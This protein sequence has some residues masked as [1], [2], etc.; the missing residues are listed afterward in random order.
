MRIV[1][2]M[3]GMQ[4]PFSSH[5]GVGR[6]TKGMVS[7]LIKKAGELHEILLALNGCFP[8]SVKHVRAAFGD[9]LPR[10]NIKIWQQYV[11]PLSGISQS[12]WT[13]RIAEYVREWFLSQFDPDVIWSTNLQ[14]GWL[15]DAV[16]SVGHLKTRALVVSTL[17]DVTPLMFEEKYL[18]GNSVRQWYLEK[19]DFA[20]QSDVI[21]T[22]SC[23][24][25]E[26]IIEFLG[27]DREK[28][29][30]CLLSCNHDI[31]NTA[32]NIGA[33]FPLSD[34]LMRG[35]YVFYVGGADEHKNL[36]RLVK[37]YSRLG[38][39]LIRQYP[40]VLAGRDVR[41]E[42]HKIMAVAKKCGLSKKNI[43]FPGFVDDA[44][45]ASL[46]R[47]CAVFVFPSYS[48]GFG[49]PCLEAMACG[50]PVVAANAT[51]LPEIMD[52]SDA[53][54]DPYDVRDMA[55][56]IHRCLAD[57]A[58]REF[59]AEYGVKR[60]QQFSWES[61]AAEILK[62]FEW[63][64]DRR[65][66]PTINDKG[67]RGTQGIDMLIAKI[68]E[69]VPG[70]EEP[71]LLQ[72]SQ[73][74][75]D[76]MT[77]EK[78]NRKIF[79]DISSLVHVD[80][81]TGIQRVTRA[82]AKILPDV[83]PEGFSV[84]TV[85]SY[86]GHRWFYFAI[87]SESGFSVPDV[88][89]LYGH[90]VDFSDGD[91]LLFLDLHPGNAI[92]KSKEI[93]RLKDRGVAVYFFVYDILPVQYPAYFTPEICQ[94][95]EQW[96]ETVF[97]ADGAICISRTVAVEL[98]SWARDKKMNFTTGFC[99]GWSH[100][101]GDI[102]DS[103][104]SVGMPQDAQACL[105]RFASAHTF[106]MV[107]TIEPRKGH[108]LVLDV[109][110]RLWQDGSENVSFVIVG[111]PAWWRSDGLEARL[112]SHPELDRRLFWLSGITD[113]YLE[114]IYAAAT[115]LI[116]ASEAEGFGLP[117]IEAARHKL[118]I[119][120]RDIPV[121]REVAGDHAFYF[122]DDNSPDTLANAIQEWLLL[123]REGRHPR[124]DDMPYLTW[125]ES[126]QN[127]L[128]IILND[129]WAYKILPDGTVKPGVV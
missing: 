90:V 62:V 21:L 57:H 105:D 93:E 33:T 111:K 78:E 74:I 50:C 44:T 126:A 18:R 27:V 10:H 101:G 125:K 103:I 129:K 77:G 58:F 96:L 69:T 79:L 12:S 72:F 68:A 26:K 30:A 63:A 22:D 114:K 120:A 24:S 1:L 104:P 47:N 64:H 35:K 43:F 89:E 110:E 88:Q 76:S 17:H 67:A 55:E 83:V 31:F 102:Q 29:Y 117:L 13:K 59:L 82:I 86:P 99:I 3:Q 60:A 97:L 108:S 73:A 4:T 94:E 91:I 95:F 75:S 124:S 37:A 84:A 71:A 20:R 107:G 116:M 121:F 23:F 118:P 106:L 85:F 9:I 48:E 100:I 25:R 115:C 8:D 45:L 49:L 38:A 87:A 40:L 127:L 32:E 128:D 112:C 52:F 19:I 28:V 39:D 36:T 51:S 70:T 7:A 81:V 80:H 5:R 122:P 46:Y 41:Q 98:E 92:S 16:T 11:S 61:G 42:S 56:K 113:E 14:E 53:L 65:V 66:K 119:I 2:D 123:Y 34:V 54:F 15:D 6:Y 109:F